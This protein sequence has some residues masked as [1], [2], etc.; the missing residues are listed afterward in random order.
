MTLAQPPDHGPVK[1]KEEIKCM[2]HCIDSFFSVTQVVILTKMISKHNG[3]NMFSHFVS[4]MYKQASSVALP[5]W[6]YKNILIELI[7]GLYIQHKL[8]K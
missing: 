1:I 3:K 5:A 4:F 2:N 8:R 7:D 6:L